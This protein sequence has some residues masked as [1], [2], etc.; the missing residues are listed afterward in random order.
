MKKLLILRGIPGSGKS[1]Y[2]KKRYDEF[3]K[4][5]FEKAKEANKPVEGHVKI[6]SADDYFIRPDGVYDWSV[7][8]LKNAHKWCKGQVELN[9]VGSTP[10]HV[11]LDVGVKDLII[12]DNTNTRHWEYK[13]Y[14]ELAEKHGYEVEIQ[15][16]GEFDE[17]SVKKYAE[18]N[19][20]GVPAEHVVKM[21]ERFEF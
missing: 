13:E 17:E 8:T 4:E 5:R 2:A 11:L 15:V 6:C 14:V 18:R 12:L 1:T 7:K 19:T 3:Y 10:F 9:M 20:H 16:V 21:A